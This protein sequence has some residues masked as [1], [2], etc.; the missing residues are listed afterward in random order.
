M[1]TLR[2]LSKTAFMLSTLAILLSISGVASA[3]A[4]WTAAFCLDISG[5]TDPV[6]VYPGGTLALT[7]STASVN[8]KFVVPSYIPQCPNY[9]IVTYTDNSGNWSGQGVGYSLIAPVTATA[10]TVYLQS[11]AKSGSCNS[12]A[13]LGVP[14]YIMKINNGYRMFYGN[15]LGK[16]IKLHMKGSIDLNNIQCS[17][18]LE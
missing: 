15:N 14:F 5:L 1:N 10:P 13:S 9:A 3:K 6:Y 8:G 12:S 4:I 11:G 7:T 16:I 2:K 18:T 17:L